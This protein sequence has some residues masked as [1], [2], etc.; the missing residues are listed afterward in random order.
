MAEPAVQF[1]VVVNDEEQ[2]S[3]WPTRQ[4]LPPGWRQAGFT[5]TEQQCLDHIAAVWTDMRPLSLRRWMSE[6]ERG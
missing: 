2:Y 4:E 1:H 5:G 6:R 3:I